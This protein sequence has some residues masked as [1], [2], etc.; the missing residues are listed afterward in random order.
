MGSGLDSDTHH[1]KMADDSVTT[2]ATTSF[3]QGVREYVPIGATVVNVK[4]FH[5]RKRGF[6]DFHEWESQDSA[7]YIGRHNRFLGV[8]ASKW[9]NPF[10]LKDYD[11]EECLKKY[12]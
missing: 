12:E 9:S 7:L 3:G 5:L 2:T 6:K 11:R 8:A 4:A 10:K 1:T